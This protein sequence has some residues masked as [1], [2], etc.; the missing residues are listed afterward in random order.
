VLALSSTSCLEPEG[1]PKKII[2]CINGFEYSDGII[3]I[4]KANNSYVECDGEEI[5]E[6]SLEN[7]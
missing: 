2:T 4:D 1:I 3:V 6:E 7:P 5:L